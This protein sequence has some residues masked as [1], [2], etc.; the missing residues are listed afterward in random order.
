MKRVPFVTIVLAL[1]LTAC[2]QATPTTDPAQIQ[3]SAVA[4]ANTMVALTQAAVPTE[5]PVPP[6]ALPSPTP[7]PSPTLLALPTLAVATL[8]TQ[9]TQT[10]GSSGGNTGGSGGGNT[11]GDPCQAALTT[12]PGGPL[13]QVRVLN[14]TKA[15]I[16]LSLYLQKNSFGDCGYRSFNLEKGGS[17]VA[18]LPLG[19]YFGGAFVNDPKKPTKAFGSG[20]LNTAGSNGVVTVGTD[21]IQIQ[22]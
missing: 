13:I 17:T 7:L 6:T 14:A 16:V 3:A 10:G 2:A 20:C 18:S 8:P 22:Q 19:C 1:L 15:S 4:A 11:S 12:K 21:V 5:T 9:P